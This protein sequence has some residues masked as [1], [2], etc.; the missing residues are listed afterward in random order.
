MTGADR[1]K[2]NKDAGFSL[3]ELLIAVII[4]AIIVIPLMNLFVSSNRI[5]IKSRKTLRATTAAQDIMEGLKAY[6]IEEVRAQF[7]DPASGFYVIDSRLI[8]GGMAEEPSLEVDSSGNPADGLYVFSMRDVTMQGSK[9]DAKIVVDGRGYMTSVPAGSAMKDH[10][11]HL[12]SPT[13]SETYKFNDAAMADARSID[14]NNGT[15]VETDKIRKAVLKS[16]FKDTDMRDAVELK[17]KAK[18]VADAN[19]DDAIDAICFKSLVTSYPVPTIFDQVS[20]TITIDLTVS[21]EV[22]E[23]GN[24]K[25][26]MEVTQIYDFICKDAA[27]ANVEVHTAGDMGSGIM[28]N[29]Q[30]CGSIARMVDAETGDEEINVN[31]FYY[32]L[33]GASS[34]DKIII[35]NGSG[36]DLNLLIAKQRYEKPGSADPANPDPEYLSDSQLMAAEQLPYRANI[37][38]KDGH[39]AAYNKDKFAIKTNLGLNLVGEKYLAGAAIEIPSQLT[40]NGTNMDLSGSSGMNIFTLD[41]V[42]SPM[43]KDP[44]PGEGTELIY[45][46]QVGIYEEGAAASGFPEEMRKVVIEGSM[47]N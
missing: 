29:S 41:G 18:G 47:T 4:L 30:S 37:E 42:R 13:G 38:I 33:Y 20:R 28:V 35:N 7:A 8:K 32:P 25:V 5:N 45:D 1:R 11:A 31:L 39:G 22:D 44:L 10:D 27:G 14:K 40:V 23:D 3:V 12:V 26:D 16:V 19:I 6:N 9:F 24:P 17:L 21:A 46:V 2:L 43:G 36:A 15:F 34:P